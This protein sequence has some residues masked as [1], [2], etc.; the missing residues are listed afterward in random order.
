[1]WSIQNIK[2]Y[3]KTFNNILMPWYASYLLRKGGSAHSSLN[4]PPRL[5]RSI[6]GNDSLHSQY[7]WY[8]STTLSILP[9]LCNDVDSTKGICSWYQRLLFKWKNYSQPS[10]AR[11]IS[12]YVR[13]SWRWFLSARDGVS[14]IVYGFP[15]PCLLNVCLALL[16]HPKAVLETG[17]LL[18]GVVLGVKGCDGSRGSLLL[19]SWSVSWS[20][21]IF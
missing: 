15:L 14:D 2:R 8:T 11:Y 20:F 18:R 19:W 12:Q 3:Y 13:S 4:F 10:A 17:Y 1:M 16:N 5:A 21:W 7:L 6:S 9:R